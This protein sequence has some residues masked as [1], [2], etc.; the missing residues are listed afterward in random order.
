MYQG[1]LYFV[2]FTFL[3]CS[4]PQAQA[5]VLLDRIKERRQQKESG[6]VSKIAPSFA[7]V[8]YGKDKKQTVDV[9][10][11]QDAHNAPIIVMVHGGGWKY[12]DKTMRGKVSSKASHYL[13]NGYVFI[14]VDY[15]LLPT[16]PDKQ[17]QDVASA[18][19]M[20]QEK[21]RSWC[22]DPSRIVLMGH[23]A[24]AHL[25]ALVSAHPAT[26]LSVGLKP[27]A[28][29]ISL[30]SAA[31]DLVAIMSGKHVS[32][33]DDAFGDDKEYWAQNSPLSQLSGDAL[34]M[35][36]LC[37]TTRKDDSCANA[38]IFVTAGQDLGKLYQIF[39]VEKSHKDIIADV[40]VDHEYTGR[41]DQFVESVLQR[42]NLR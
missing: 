2:A 27:W 10:I 35:L 5:G 41:I 23:S 9:Y 24:G 15:R 39:P 40:G 34:P 13:K 25:V 1:L 7:D 14:S 21:S 31:L 4:I 28:G 26:W 29:T 20:V 17:A 32:L 42:K 37:S 22:G 6:D 12:G 16:P 30:D 38:Q 3:C 8:A 36:A 18:L 11:P 33:Y 19:A